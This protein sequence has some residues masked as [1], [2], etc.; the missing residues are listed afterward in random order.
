MNYVGRSLQTWKHAACPNLSSI[1]I[2]LIANHLLHK[3]LFEQ[4][5]APDK[6]I[7]AINNSDVVIAVM[8]VTGC[9]K[10]SFIKKVTGRSD[11]KVGDNLTSGKLDCLSL[12]HTN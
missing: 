2:F 11:V 7:M 10:S 9:G 12:G 1:S 3:I 4:Q 8:G 5:R 6:G